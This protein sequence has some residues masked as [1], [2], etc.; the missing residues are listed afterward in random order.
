MATRSTAGVDGTD[1]SYGTNEAHEAHEANTSH[2]SHQSSDF[3]ALHHAEF[4]ASLAR[5]VQPP[6]ICGLSRLAKVLIVWHVL[7]PTVLRSLPDF[8]VDR[9]GRVA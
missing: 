2:E 9:L 4:Q 3:R 1:A 5:A 7:I 8:R 6:Q